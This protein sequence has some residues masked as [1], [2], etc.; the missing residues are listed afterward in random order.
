MSE[1]KLQMNANDLP[2]FC[3]L[4]ASYETTRNDKSYSEKDL[5]FGLSVST[6]ALSVARYWISNF[7]K[8]PK[9]CSWPCLA[10]GRLTFALCSYNKTNYIHWFLKFIFETKLY[11]FRTVPLTIIIIKHVCCVYGETLLMMDKGTVRNM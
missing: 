8:F 2:N 9:I 3:L 7:A 6:P 1:G 10:F 4:Y 5:I 11:M